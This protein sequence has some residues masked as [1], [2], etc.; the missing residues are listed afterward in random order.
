VNLKDPVPCVATGTALHG[1][2]VVVVCS[3]GVDLDLVPF[4]LD[5][6]AMHAPSAELV[7]VVPQRDASPVTAALA[8]AAVQ[9][10]RI[11]AW[12]RN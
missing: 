12:T 2:P 10:P 9:P 8:A 7:L 1:G 4:A 3:T 6:R 11:V 5:A